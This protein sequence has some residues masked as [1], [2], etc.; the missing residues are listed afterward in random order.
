M[1]AAHFPHPC[2]H[3]DQNSTALD[4][5]VRLLPLLGG[6]GYY[7]PRMER[8]TSGPRGLS[9]VDGSNVR[10]NLLIA[11]V[12]CAHVLVALYLSFSLPPWQDEISTLV[13]TG[14]GIGRA[15]HRG[16]E[17]EQQAPG[18]F[19]LMAAWRKVFSSLAGVRL[20]STACSAATII[21]SVLLVRALAPWVSQGWAAAVMA[22]NPLLLFSAAEA[23]LY[24]FAYLLG[25]ILCL[26]FA[27]AYWRSD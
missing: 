9:N 27:R 25:A 21:V 1:P 8:T 6:S 24:A 12:V 14:S 11:A 3:S 23:R 18:Y 26:V 15:F 16:V 13:T 4:G 20:F 22:T 5:S 10:T 7:R 19:V 17:F 2:L